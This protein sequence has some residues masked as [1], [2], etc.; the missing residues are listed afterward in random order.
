MLLACLS[1][2]QQFG[3]SHESVENLTTETYCR[4]ERGREGRK[5]EQRE[6][7]KEKE[8]GEGGKGR[9][10]RKEIGEGEKK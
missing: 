8:E 7:R 3:G 10:G 2:E 1:V 4:D 9:E 5:S 6:R